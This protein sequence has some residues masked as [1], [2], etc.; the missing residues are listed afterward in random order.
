MAIP[1]I[2]I[3]FGMPKPSKPKGIMAH[4][5]WKRIQ[6]AH[7]P[8]ERRFC[9]TG[10]HFK[11]GD[12][13]I[14]PKRKEQTIRLYKSGKIPRK[15][16][17][18]F[19]TW[20]EK[21]T[22]N[23]MTG[24]SAIKQ[25]PP[26]REAASDRSVN[27]RPPTDRQR[28]HSVGGDAWAALF[29]RGRIISSRFSRQHKYQQDKYVILQ[30][31]MFVHKCNFFPLLVIQPVENPSSGHFRSL[32]CPFCWRKGVYIIDIYR[33]GGRFGPVLMHATQHTHT[34]TPLEDHYWHK[35]DGGADDFPLYRKKRKSGKQARV[36]QRCHCS[37][38]EFS[39]RVS[40]KSVAEEGW[41]KF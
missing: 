9:V 2:L 13:K 5:W 20:K 33:G 7:F 18:F 6:K 32:P 31:F 28:S 11:A 22:E 24:K 40:R 12:W 3:L 4:E 16:D 1:G 30:G 19:S 37:G 29:R 23:W 15:D 39:S 34:L 36:S 21:Q 35:D 10:T 27:T 41:Y 25:S 38:L 17:R 8:V 14:S 26:P